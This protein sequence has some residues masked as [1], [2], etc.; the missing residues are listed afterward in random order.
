MQDINKLSSSFISFLEE[1]SLDD[2]YL[3][4][5]DKNYHPELKANLLAFSDSLVALK[6]E[7]N[8]N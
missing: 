1:N 4:L 3:D 7:L 6:E 8:K 5:A 2:Q